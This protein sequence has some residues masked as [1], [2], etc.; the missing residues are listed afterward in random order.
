[1]LREAE[2]R[3]QEA[4]ADVEAKKRIREQIEAD[5]RERAEKAARD[6]ALREGRAAPEATTSVAG[7]GLTAV[8]APSSA[9]T[10]NQ[11]RLRVRC[12]D[13]TWTGTMDADATLQQ[14][15][16]RLQEDGKASGPLT[17]STSFPRKVMPDED[18][19]KTLRALGLVPNAALEASSRA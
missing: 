9:S 13:G 15:E 2:K 19:S 5:K 8:T 10:S 4:R 12:P 1:M 17:F 14:L 6:K 7:A 3:K 11:A 18:K 16:D